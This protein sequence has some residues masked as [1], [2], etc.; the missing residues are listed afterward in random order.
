MK[1]TSQ[2]KIKCVARSMTSYNE[3]ET[4]YL[5]KDTDVNDRYAVKWQV[6]EHERIL[7]KSK[8]VIIHAM[9][10]AGANGFAFAACT[11]IVVLY[12][13]TFDD[14]T[15]LI[16]WIVWFS[17]VSFSILSLILS[18][19]ADTVG[20]DA[21]LF[22]AFIVAGIGVLMQA[23]ASS[24]IIWGIGYILSRQPTL[25]IFIGYVAAMLP[26][27]DSKQYT[28]TFYQIFAAFYLIGPLVSGMWYVS[29]M[30]DAR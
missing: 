25:F 26:L 11:N 22:G 10:V 16:S 12:A 6:E 20:F 3:R 23:V 14:N 24:F 13:R 9:V 15:T 29:N 21:L 17:S 18:S 8:R 5:F 1:V 19:L 28:A 7:N 2:S 4:E 30:F 27:I